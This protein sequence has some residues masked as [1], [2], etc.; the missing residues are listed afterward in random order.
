MSLRAPA[1]KS[2][3]WS[4][5]PL[6][7]RMAASENDPGSGRA[8]SGSDTMPLATAMLLPAACLRHTH[9][10]SSR[11]YGDL[12]QCQSTCHVLFF[13]LQDSIQINF[14]LTAP[15]LVIFSISNVT[16]STPV[17][18]SYGPGS[19]QVGNGRIPVF[20]G[21][22]NDIG[23]LTLTG[24]NGSVLYPSS[25]YLIQYWIR[26]KFATTDTVAEATLV[27]TGS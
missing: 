6:K 7:L 1:L 20:T 25:K 15:G 22:A 10:L 4:R 16:L 5:E 19:M 11:H 26:D 23:D 12:C 13:A 27:T 18:S 2:A 24:C 17:D 21:G 14:A 9:D 8:S 3:R